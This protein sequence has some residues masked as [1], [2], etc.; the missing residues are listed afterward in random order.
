MNIRL[1]GKIS[2]YR[3]FN[4]YF[5]K[6]VINCYLLHISHRMTS[7]HKKIKFFSVL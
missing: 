2:F 3:M 5:V 6:D 4:N 1:S 7:F